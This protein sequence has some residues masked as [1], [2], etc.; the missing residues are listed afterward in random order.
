[1]LY[2][3][4]IKQETRAEYQT[5]KDI[6]EAQGFEILGVVIAEIFSK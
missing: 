5:I 1:M 6:L 4:Q 2:W 3:N